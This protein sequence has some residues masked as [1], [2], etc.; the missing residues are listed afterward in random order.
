MAVLHFDGAILIVTAG[1]DVIGGLAPA[2]GDGSIGFEA[3]IV[4]AP[5]A[6]TCP[7]LMVMLPNECIPKPPFEVAMTRP[8]TMLTP[9]FP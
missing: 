2:E 9:E 4:V 3:V 8:P 1:I 7:P 6:L 5:V